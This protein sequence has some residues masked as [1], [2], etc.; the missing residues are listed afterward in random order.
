MKHKH[1]L[2]NKVKI[3][4][5]VFLFSGLAQ[6][7]PSD[8]LFFKLQSSPQAHV[9]I[10]LSALPSD[11]PA[12]QVFVLSPDINNVIKN[13]YD[14]EKLNSIF[15][16]TAETRK[17]LLTE[18][19]WGTFIQATSFEDG[20][21]KSETHYD[22]VWLRDSLWG[23]LA[24]SSQNENKDAAKRV[25]LTLWD[26]MA[27]PKQLER[28]DKVINNPSLLNNKDGQ[29]NAIHIRFDSNSPSF[30]DVLEEGK[31][32]QWNHKQNDALGLYLDC[33]IQAV[34]SG[35]FSRS[36]WEKGN[37]LNA[38]VK[39][40][41]YF[42][43]SHFYDM[44]DS[45]AWEE[46][47]RLNTSSVALVTSGLER[48]NTLLNKSNNK[49]EREFKDDLLKTSKNLKLERHLEKKQLEKMISKGYDLI[50]YQLMLGGES[51]NYKHDDPRYRTAD[52][53]L[54]NLIYP[55]KLS[56]LTLEQKKMV[57]STVKTLAGSYG[58]KRY[59]NDNYQSAN[60]WFNEIKTDTS[61]DSH[62]KR[63]E[64]FIPFTEAQWFFDSW[65]AMSSAIIYKESNDKYYFSEAIQFMNRSLSQ[66]TAKDMI[67]A[68][69]KAIPA[70]ALPES[71]NFLHHSGELKAIPSPI[72]P[73]NWSK[74]SMTLMFKNIELMLSDKH[75]VS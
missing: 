13:S 15:D 2:W 7:T 73:L 48:L 3:L 4:G 49:N 65:Y 25:L 34:E 24:L 20:N 22:A 68:N 50:S 32:Q 71:I 19:P 75:K 39:L 47:A 52:A 62:N 36:D 1:P 37:R 17:L 56:R 51:P 14:K 30:E 42:D 72:I 54:L 12:Y 57:L 74:A 45:G 31:P 28:M 55:A 29:M 23:Y 60:F 43:K 5:A 61:E 11:Y 63:K 53:A 59:F 8:E 66:I 58:I 44:P 21:I 27:T 38:L 6:A 69:G 70:L 41:T 9:K 16:K 64:G 10:L 40:V 26:Y 46:D 35:L 33:V 67:G 18:K